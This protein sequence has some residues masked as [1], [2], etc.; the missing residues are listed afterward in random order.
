MDKSSSKLLQVI[1]QYPKNL[2]GWIRKSSY[3]VC[4][5]ALWLTSGCT[6]N[7]FLLFVL[8]LCIRAHT[9]TDSTKSIPHTL[10]DSEQNVRKLRFFHRPWAQ[11]RNTGPLR[12]FYRSCALALNVTAVWQW[13]ENLYISIG[14]RLYC[15]T[16]VLH[17]GCIALRLYCTMAVLHYGCIALRLYCTTAVLHYGCIALWLYC[18]MAVLPYKI[19]SDLHAE[20]RNFSGILK[21]LSV[22]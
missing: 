5:T 17:Y 20:D 21:M 22:C 11:P 6:Q 8:V 16:A 13:S 10:T 14:L 1:L 12:L 2:F 18:T 7:L 3:N 9:A 15:T 4:V 19:L